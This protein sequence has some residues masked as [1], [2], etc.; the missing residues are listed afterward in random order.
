MA[1]NSVAGSKAGACGTTAPRWT[2]HRARLGKPRSLVR[3]RS[4]RPDGWYG[5]SVV[6]TINA[7]LWVLRLYI[8]QTRRPSDLWSLIRA[9]WVKR[10]GTMRVHAPV[11]GTVG[12]PRRD[13]R[14]VRGR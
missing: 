12:R 2:E 4:C 13:Q 11:I 10:N 5:R 3:G 9:R 1:A 7:E 6:D 14:H 8:Q